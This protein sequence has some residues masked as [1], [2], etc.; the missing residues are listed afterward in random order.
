MNVYLLDCNAASALLD[1]LN[2]KHEGI[3]NFVR[4]L[5]EQRVYLSQIAVGE[6]KYGHRVHTIND[7]H[8]RYQE[9]LERRNL[10][11]EAI[12]EFAIKHL[13]KHTTEVYAQLRAKLFNQYAP[14]NKR[15]IVKSRWPEALLEHTTGRELGIDEND[16]WIASQAVEG[17]LVLITD[18]KMTQIRSVEANL[19]CL[20]ISDLA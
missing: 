1:T 15:N 6:M 7:S 18:D 4:N 13:T 3:S 10:L 12:E 14:R 9:I 5:G 16:I 20:S 11:E 17:N 2:P 19:N 8:P